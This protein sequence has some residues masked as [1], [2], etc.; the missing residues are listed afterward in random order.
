MNLVSKL[1]YSADTVTS[2][3][4]AV[5]YMKTHH[6]DMLILNII[7]TPFD[8]STKCRLRFSMT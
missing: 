2:V 4:E 5:K 8:I 6:A 3:E 7:M 1:G